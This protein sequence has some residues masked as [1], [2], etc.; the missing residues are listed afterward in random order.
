LRK[1][2]EEKHNSRRVQK[3]INEND[4]KRLL[5]NLDFKNQMER[6]ER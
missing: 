3:Y 2:E 6:A 4:S 1:I 5:E